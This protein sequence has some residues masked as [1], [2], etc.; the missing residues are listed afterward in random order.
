MVDIGAVSKCMRGFFLLHFFPVQVY[1][2]SVFA[3]ILFGNG[4]SGMYRCKHVEIYTKSEVIVF[5]ELADWL[6][7]Q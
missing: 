7:I 4:F 2:K 1:F 3:L 6:Y 5:W